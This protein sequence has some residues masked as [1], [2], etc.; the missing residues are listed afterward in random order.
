MKVLRSRRLK[1]HSEGMRERKAK[2]TE[3]REERK[4]KGGTMKKHRREVEMI[5]GTKKNTRETTGRGKRKRRRDT[6]V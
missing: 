6:P 4:G 3:E 5:N 2:E 1:G